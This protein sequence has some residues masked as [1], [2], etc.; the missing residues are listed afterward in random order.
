[1]GSTSEDSIRIV[2][3]TSDAPLQIEIGSRRYVSPEP[4]DEEARQRL[5]QIIEM[6]HI[7]RTA[8]PAH[9]RTTSE[10]P[11]LVP[12]E[13]EWGAGEEFNE[14]FW[15]RLLDVI[16][17]RDERLPVR[18]SL[19]SEL[20]EASGTF[21]EE[22]ESILQSR[23]SGREPPLESQI[24][25]TAGLGGNLQILVGEELYHTVSEIP[26]EEARRVLQ[27]TIS[28]WENRH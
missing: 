21:I 5:K 19:D 27:E 2:Q 8:I 9:G 11:T 6:L 15:R 3:P 24:R 7:W 13:G 20:A 23:L 25:L 18:P 10:V 1:M 16:L 26:N 12:A 28:E 17:M 14:P 4:L 22:L